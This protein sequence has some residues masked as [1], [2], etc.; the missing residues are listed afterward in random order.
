MTMFRTL[1][2]SVALLLCY[3]PGTS[4]QNEPPR[5]PEPPRTLEPARPL[6]PARVQEPPRPQTLE[7]QVRYRIRADRDERIRQFRLLEK[8]LADLGFEDD[9]K[10]DPDRDLDILDPTAE[11]FTGKIP[12]ARVLEVLNDPRVL[13]ILFAPA[14]Y[15]YPDDPNGPVAVRVTLRGGLSPG[16]QQLLHFQVLERLEKLGFREALGYD[17]RGYTQLKGT[18]PY[19]NL[20]RLVKD[21]REEPAG[22]FAPDTPPDR[23]PRP[24]ADRNP[25]LWVEVMPRPE[26]PPAFVPQVV[27]PNQ[28]RMTPELRAV[29]ADP[30]RK[31][32]PLRV[33]A[34]FTDPVEERSE[35]L[36]S[37][38]AIRFPPTAKLDAAGN[39]VRG[40]DGSPAL[41]EGASLEGFLGNMAT[42]RFDRPADVERLASDPNV[43]TLGL[44]REAA[45][46][47]TTIPAP[48]RPAA[49][50][51]VLKAS[52]LEALH[53]RGYTGAGVKVVVV[54][55]DFS[56]ASDLIGTVL[57]KKTRILDL[58]PELSDEIQPAPSDP[59]RAGNGTAVARAVARAAPQA[60]L[61]LVRIDPGAHFQLSGLL[62]LIGG[63][64]S[65]S[66]AL[67]S[68]LGEIAR[69]TTEVNRRKTEAV[70]EYRQAFEDLADDE[71][72]RLRR[73]RAK[74]QLDAVIAEQAELARRAERLTAYQKAVVEGLR[75]ARVVVNTLG[76]E[77]GYPLDALSSLSRRLDKLTAPQPPRVTRPVPKPANTTQPPIV[78]VQAASAAGP[79]VWGGPFLDANRD[80]TMEFAPAD[81]PL[82]APNW[83]NDM[84][85]LGLRS[86]TGE[87]R[88]ELP[89][90]TR[91][92]FTMQWR[93][94]LD[95]NF[96]SVDRP[97][98]PVVLRVFRQIDPTGEK[99]PSDEMA[100]VARSAGGPYPVFLTET[101]VVFEQV[102]DF[103]TA[104]A[105][106][107]ALIVAKGYEPQA[108]LPALK[109]QVEVYPRI[110]IDTAATKPDDPRVVFRSYFTTQA[111]VG[112]PGDSLGVITVGVPT[113]GELS[114]GGTG[115][116]L[117]GKPD[118]LG[119]DSLEVGGPAMRGTGVATG[120]VGG[121]A[122]V[123]V[124]AGAPGGNVFRSVGF[125]PGQMAVVPEAWLR[126]LPPSDR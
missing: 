2:A 87:T 17:T 60:E 81:V 49:A 83:S 42:I 25:V 91:M 69:K 108:L 33:M 104:E 67:R 46:T 44:P 103:T 57:P 9:R 23:L 1:L 19:K 20:P 75:G 119:P 99:V 115:L 89:A 8:H 114:G 107:Y 118:L 15:T 84:N 65:Y 98:F 92:R 27:P 105:G 32:T 52:G 74:K 30:A 41:T 64:S 102:L 80:G 82:P 93:E 122:A 96:P 39:P 126:F 85:F 94:P 36:R 21:L 106:R 43:L 111:G 7:I 40:P 70:T 26:P 79:A 61:V 14:G 121:L 53:R 29:V 18:L 71:P 112:M 78:W 34:L 51:E 66:P 101:F 123:L 110:V 3:S 90:G 4:Q 72:T 62:E 73:E 22:W 125:A 28:A 31:E 100:E 38:L 5:N 68:R 12:S 50:E 16:T 35:A 59:R 56:G 24:L 10:D 11:R 124:Q 47:V 48:G 97:L 37:Q 13:N 116:I 45:E 63:Q 120:F 77:S 86:A 54:G 95:P 109:R 88:A 6:E 55:S 58:T 76:W 113:P 117:R